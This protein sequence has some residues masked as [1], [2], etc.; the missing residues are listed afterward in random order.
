MR[1]LILTQYFPP[2]TGA[3]QNR[4]FELA[5]RLKEKG[6]DVEILT[7]MPNYPKMEIM[8]GYK[9]LK[10]KEE[11]IEGLKVY[12][13]KIYISKEK[14][15]RKRLMVYFSFVFSSYKVGKKLGNYDYL[16]CESPP[17]FLGY[18]AMRLSKKLKAKLI[19]NVSDL[20]PESAEK[21]GVVTNKFFLKMAYNLE[22]KIYRKSFFIS[23]QATGIVGSIKK[24]FPEKD[25]YW[26][27]NGVDTKTIDPDKIE[28]YGLREKYNIPGDQTVLF[29][30][31]ILGHAQGLQIIVNAATHFKGEKVTFVL[32]GSGPEKDDLL[33]LQK[34]VEADNVI[35]AEPVGRKEVAHVLKEADASIIPLRKLDVFEGVIPSKIFEVLAMAKPII[36][37]VNGESKA[38]FID[39]AKAGLHYEP[40]N[41]DALVKAIRYALNHPVEMQE[42][43]MNGR[44]YVEEK[45][46]RE[47]LVNNFYE[48]LKDKHQ[49]I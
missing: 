49:S 31:G 26:L 29:Y 5:L 20:W 39:E 14:G 11:E 30:G 15:I 6:I 10:Y 27:S 38:F 19:F 18:S 45:F 41:T 47:L 7:A 3:P 17:L 34:E 32:M 8:E 25:V 42:K 13:S 22:A 12:R 37:G 36:L 24:R 28:P 44:A 43:G 35:F 21:M 2:E 33:A 23:G 40:E 9:G 4:L 1:L 48:Y 46:D 16:M